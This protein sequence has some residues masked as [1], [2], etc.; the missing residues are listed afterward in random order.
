M[1]QRDYG[2]ERGR[3]VALRGRNHTDSS[4]VFA[5]LVLIAMSTAPAI[6]QTYTT[7]GQT[8][9]CDDCDGRTC[10]HLRNTVTCN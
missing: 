7:I 10:T 8:T 9:S 1:R 6:A 5:F 2:S 3:R 4:C